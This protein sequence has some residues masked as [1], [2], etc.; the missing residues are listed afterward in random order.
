MRGPSSKTHSG[1]LGRFWKL[2]TAPAPSLPEKQGPFSLNPDRGCS[3]S[4]VLGCLRIP[5][6]WGE[7]W[8]T[9]T[10]SGCCQYKPQVTANPTVWG[11]LRHFR[12][13]A[14]PPSSPFYPYIGP[15]GGRH[16][17]DEIQGLGFQGQGL[18]RSLFQVERQGQI[19]GRPKR[20]NGVWRMW[21][22][23]E[24]AACWEKNLEKSGCMKKKK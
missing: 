1:Q 13:L 16:F 5:H 6:M 22:T 21:S 19:Q 8:V 12:I 20:R 24:R 15:D 7:R 9:H 2:P 18:Q 14:L 3:P 10:V 23:Q 11:D 4:H 17:H